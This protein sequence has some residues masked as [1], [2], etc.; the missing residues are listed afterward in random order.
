MAGTVGMP[1]CSDS[2]VT[3]PVKPRMEPTD[4]SSPPEI[5]SSIIPTAMVASTDKAS[6]IACRLPTS[7]NTGDAN[8]IAAPMTISTTL[9]AN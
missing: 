6:R 1:A 4:R 9:S 7:R 3:T 2:P 5:K 8:A